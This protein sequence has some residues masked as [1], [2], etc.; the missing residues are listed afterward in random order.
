MLPNTTIGHAI[1]QLCQAGQLRKVQCKFLKENMYYFNPGL[2]LR[3]GT[4][5]EKAQ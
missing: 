4:V 3:E 2:L 5:K 1:A